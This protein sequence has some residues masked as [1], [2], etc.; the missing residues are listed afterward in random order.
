MCA[1]RKVEISN[2]EIHNQRD[3]IFILCDVE[4]AIKEIM[5]AV[6]NVIS[7]CLPGEGTF[8][9]RLALIYLTMKRSVFHVNSKHPNAT[10][11]LRRKL[12]RNE[13]YSFYCLNDAFHLGQCFSNWDPRNLEVRRRRVRV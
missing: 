4:S 5:K 7:R 9:P 2:T 12:G 3:S 11:T 6:K 8:Y 1:S 10:R 13:V